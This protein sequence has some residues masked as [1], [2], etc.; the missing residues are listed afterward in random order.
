[1]RK[2]PVADATIKTFEMIEN[3]FAEHRVWFS[4]PDA[5]RK[6][7]HYSPLEENYKR[8]SLKWKAS[9]TPPQN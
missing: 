9:H 4:E 8:N 5:F 6:I 3:S 2:T 1:M 7:W